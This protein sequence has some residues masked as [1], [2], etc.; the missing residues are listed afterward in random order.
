VPAR[1]KFLRAESTETGH[2]AETVTLLSLARPDV[3]FT[4]VSQGRPLVEAPAVAEAAA[5]IHQLFGREALERLAPV[6]GGAEWAR[7]SGFVAR[8]GR[9]A[10]SRPVLRLF[11]NG[12]P[13]R[14]RG[15]ARALAE[16]YRRSGQPDPRGESFLFLSVPL[17]LVDVNVHPA[18]SEVRF[19]EAR[20]VWEAVTQAVSAALS[21]E[22]RARVAGGVSRVAEATERY[23]AGPAPALPAARA[24]FTLPEAAVADAGPRVLGQHRNIYIVASDG[25]ELVLVDQHTAHE[26]VRFERLQQ[27]LQRRAVESQRLL[28]PAV[29]ELQPRLRPLLDEHSRALHELGF[30]LQPFGG[31]ALRIGAVPAMLGTRAPGPSRPVARGAAA[32]AGG[33]RERRLARDGRARAAG[34]DARVS[35]LGARRRASVARADGRDRRGSDEGDS[36]HAVS[37]RKADAGARAGGRRGALVRPLRLAAPVRARLRP[38]RASGPSMRRLALYAL[39][40]FLQVTGLLVTLMAATAYFG[41][42]NITA[43]LK[44]MLVG[45]CFFVP[46]WLL[47][48]RDPR[49][50]QSS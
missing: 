31:K 1:K 24:L 19:A 38:R 15:I 17:E 37:T 12:R 23:L 47:A 6:D 22:S 40:R 8:A 44:L 20:V 33:A 4:L 34:G 41:S 3:G 43:M 49:G 46:G 42:P 48:R 30:E 5:R 39:G 2:V 25:E 21:R 32:R 50:G 18:K 16:G 36:S 26:R 7:L 10:G 35:L 29:F 13:V 28:T 27:A 9:Q 14:D 45:V 11:V